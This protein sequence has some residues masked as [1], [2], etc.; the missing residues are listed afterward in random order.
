[1]DKIYDEI[2][3]QNEVA[4]I[5]KERGLTDRQIQLM[6]CGC[7]MADAVLKVSNVVPP[8]EAVDDFFEYLQDKDKDGL[9]PEGRE[10]VNKRLR[11]IFK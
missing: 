10:Y 8:K 11:D 7:S 6:I 5:G 3:Y 1:M 4:R 9:D 2:E